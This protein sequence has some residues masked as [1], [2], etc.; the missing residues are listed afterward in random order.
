MTQ[1][2]E[3]AKR[4]SQL[5]RYAVLA[6]GLIVGA[7]ALGAL[8]KSA[9]DS[10]FV[11]GLLQTRF[12]AFA[13]ASVSGLQLILF[14]A[15]LL[16]QTAPLLM[17]LWFLWRVF[18]AI[19]SSG[20]VDAATALLVRGTGLWFGAAALVM[21]VSTPLTSL[22]AS[23]G[24]LPGQRFLSVGFE[25]QHLLAILLSAVLIMLGHVLALAADIAHDNRL[26]N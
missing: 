5:M 12:G 18:G 7:A 3:Q 2:L 13:P 22:I 9:M 19:A 14:T 16:L 1:P 17:A 21:L 4:L 15:L 10:A 25:T 8:V 24:A 20:G 26:I 23:I 11:P 6:L